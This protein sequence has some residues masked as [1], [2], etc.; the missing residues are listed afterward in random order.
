MAVMAVAWESYMWTPH[1][2]ETEASSG[3]V[4]V[5][6]GSTKSNAWFR[7]KWNMLAQQKI[8]LM[9]EFYFYFLKLALKQQQ[10]Q[11]KK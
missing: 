3:Q 4:F 9:G 1:S 6:N 8:V 11:K 10:Q 2:G 5:L 7:R